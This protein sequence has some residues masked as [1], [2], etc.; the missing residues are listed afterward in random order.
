MDNGSC[1]P[2]EL[3]SRWRFHLLEEVGRGT[4]GT[5]WKARDERT[6]NLVAVKIA[7]DELAAQTIAD[8][9]E[10]LLLVDSPFI[11]TV[12]DLGRV[13]GDV[14]GVAPGS[15]Y[16]ALRWVPGV[17]L[18][19]PSIPSDRRNAVAM[20]V[21]RDVGAA[22]DDLH[23]AGM[24]HGDVKPDNILVS[25]EEGS[26]RAVLVDLGY[27]TEL[28]REGMVG[29]T[30]R[31]APPELGLGR[32]SAAH[33]LYGLGVCLS[34]VIE[35][36]IAQAE[37]PI[38]EIWSRRLP[39]PW[40]AWTRA[41]TASQPSARPPASWIRSVAEPG[42]PRAR[43][44]GSRVRASYL[45]IRRWELERARSARRCELRGDVAPW[46]GEAVAVMRSAHELRGGEVDG[47]GTLSVSPLESAGR[48]RWLVALVG[49]S[50]TAWSLP[51]SLTEI[52]EHKLVS[53]LDRL[54]SQLD[55]ASWTLRDVLRAVEDDFSN[56]VRGRDETWTDLVDLAIG[57]VRRP[58]DPSVVERAETLVS[59][60]V[61]PVRH[62]LL[63]AESVRGT[64]NMG[65]AYAA[66]DGCSDLASEALRS[67]LLRRMGK[68]DEALTLASR[69]ARGSSNGR[70]G[71][72]HVERAAAV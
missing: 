19:P 10:T 46:L 56:Q 31:Y 67:D 14:E 70:D 57:L 36:R 42:A 28:G 9:A 63:L 39:S 72:R 55:P 47:C 5:V 51:P 49:L 15:A 64:G 24:A 45:R 32:R 1:Q 27:A 16:V 7:R 20:A 37:D 23:Q 48:K 25:T 34:E 21:A 4:S 8:E 11:P 54:E 40:G 2:P 35:P 59:R 18:D 26:V 33:D 38:E 71:S 41:L 17:R 44:G 68:L 50:A 12:I 13:P 3:A 61:L 66:L 65:R 30:L 22:L 29:A 43:G 69:L 58:V 60:G 62:R 53:V 6:D 52:P